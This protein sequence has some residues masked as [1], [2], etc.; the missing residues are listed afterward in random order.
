MRG[1]WAKNACFPYIS[2]MLWNGEKRAFSPVVL[3]GSSFLNL[4]NSSREYW[5]PFELRDRFATSPLSRQPIFT[6]QQCC[7]GKTC[8]FLH[9][10]RNILL[11]YRSFKIIFVLL[12][13]G[14]TEKLEKLKNWKNEKTEKWKNWKMKKLKNE[15]LEK[16]HFV[17]KKMFATER[18]FECSTH[19]NP[20]NN[21]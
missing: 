21:T 18:F 10:W 12:K 14:K 1:L 5:L 8:R 2:S 11:D 20:T 3:N 17:Q 9:A 16:I 7:I 19:T 4:Y 13:N 6:R 15:K